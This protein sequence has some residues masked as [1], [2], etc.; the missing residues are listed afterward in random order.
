MYPYSL[1]DLQ[2]PKNAISHVIDEL[3]MEIHHTKHHQTYINN[4]N[5]ILSGISDLQQN[6]LEEILANFRQLPIDIR[7]GLVNNGGGHLNHT[8][9]WEILVPTKHNEPF[10]E[11]RDAINVEFDGYHI[12]KQKII[13][14]GLKR[15]GSGWVWLVMNQ[16]KLEVT[17][18][19]NQENPIMYGQSALLGI[20]LW[21]HSYYL[22]YQNR[23]QEYLENILT[24]L[25]WEVINR[26]FLLA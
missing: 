10:G 18:T 7:E 8:Q 13:E 17:S 15:F 14:D 25:N 11:I 24:I 26:R 16:G 19:A 1:P 22:K 2:F 6:S 21:E 12:L 9:F 20:D 23:R 5:K 4:L 3:T